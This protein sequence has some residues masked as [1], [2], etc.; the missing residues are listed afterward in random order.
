MF[1]Y[2][3]ILPQ[4]QLLATEL[5]ELEAQCKTTVA[6]FRESAYIFAF[7]SGLQNI[8]TVF[9]FQQLYNERG[10]LYSSSALHPLCNKLTQVAII[11]Q[12]ST[13]DNSHA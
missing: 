4:L 3:R 13:T 5:R 1:E 7:L 6:L 2:T 12:S 8:E 9:Y 10:S 11:P